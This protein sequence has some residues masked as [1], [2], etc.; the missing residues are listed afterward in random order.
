MRYYNE[1]DLY[2][3]QWLRNLMDNGLIPYGDIDSRPIEEVPPEELGDYTH[4]HFFAGIGGWAFAA[5]LAGWPDERELWTGSCPC[6]PISGIGKRQGH[7]DERHLWPVF[8]NLIAKRRP[9]TVVGE[10]VAGKLGLEWLSAVRHDLEDAAYA[11]GAA[12]L[13]AA[14]VGAPHKRSRLWWTALENSDSEGRSPVG[15][16]TAGT[17]RRE[18]ERTGDGMVNPDHAGLQGHGIHADMGENENGQDTKGSLF[19]AWSDGVAVTGFDGT[20]RP[21]PPGITL[22]AHGIPRRGAKLRAFGNAIVPQVGAAFLQ[23]LL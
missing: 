11:F 20:S 19:D 9:A 18:A 17:V 21:V 16:E 3:C 12:D 8:Y 1:I 23:A 10:Q 15:K 5:K 14:G 4:C 22:L 6:Q 2:C 13:P 7:A